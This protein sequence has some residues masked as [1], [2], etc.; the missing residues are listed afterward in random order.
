M[1]CSP[2]FYSKPIQ[3][4]DELSPEKLQEYKDIFSFFD[5]DGGGSIGAEE[6]EQVGYLRMFSCLVILLEIRS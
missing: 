6:F 1:I 5:R 4:A 2:L 3:A